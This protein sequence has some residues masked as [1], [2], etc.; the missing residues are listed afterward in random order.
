MEIPGYTI[1][2]VI[3]EGGMATVY[4][5]VQ[6]SLERQVALK[7][8]AKVLVDDESFR[9]RFLKEAKIIAQ[10]HHP[11]IITIHDFGVYGDTY[12]ICQEY[13]PGGTLADEITSGLTIQRALYILKG[14]ADALEYAHAKGFVHRDIK[15]Q[16][17]LFRGDRFRSPVLTDFGIAKA[18]VP[19]QTQLTIAN[20][21]C[22][23]PAYASPEQA[24]G[25]DLDHRSDLYSLGIVFYQMLTGNVPYSA[26]DPV[27]I[28]VRHITDPVPRLPPELAATFQPFL[29]RCL[30]KEPDGRFSSAEEVIQAIS[31][32]DESTH[33][34]SLQETGVGRPVDAGSRP[35]VVL[36]G[37]KTAQRADTPPPSAGV[38]TPAAG[39][40]PYQSQVASGTP[41]QAGPRRKWLVPGVLGGLLAA[42]AIAAMAF[43]FGANNG[44]P[45]PAVA[46]QERTPEPPK[47]EVPTE[48]PALEPPEPPAGGLNRTKI[49]LLLETAEAL[50]DAGDLF[51]PSE[52]NAYLMYGKILGID[53]DNRQAIYGRT[54]IWNRQLVQVRQHIDKGQLVFAE[55][56]LD[57]MR[58]L[59]PNAPGFGPWLR[60]LRE[61]KN[62]R[63]QETNGAGLL[64]RADQ[65]YR[66]GQL[67]APPGENAFETLQAARAAE[68]DL[69]VLDDFVERLF[70]QQLALA[71]AALSENR[72]DEGLNLVGQALAVDDSRTAFQALRAKMA[73]RQAQL[74]SQDQRDDWLDRAQN[75]FEQD[76]LVGDHGE[77]TAYTLYS[78]V[79]DEDPDNPIARA[80]VRT[81][82]R[83]LAVQA[84]R[85]D[86]SGD[87]ATA[88][89]RIDAALR[90]T[91]G[92]RTL[93][94][95]RDDFLAKQAERRDDEANQLADREQ[96]HRHWLA[97]AEDLLGQGKLIG[98]GETAYAL[99]LRILGENPDNDA[100]IEG[101]R[102]VSMALGEQAQ[103]LNDAG[104]HGNALET[105]DSALRMNPR[106]RQLAAIKRAI[107]DAQAAAAPRSRP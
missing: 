101:I 6:Q 25:L 40:S 12:Y 32:I 54:E 84:R 44:Q 46:T 19:D 1:K 95:I 16:N 72:L 41:T 96:R 55:K 91:P 92:D 107:E 69:Q 26:S 64:Q 71:E 80:G 88:L 73:H 29:D 10:L 93:A 89:A 94:E 60:M 103:A 50:A 65:Q 58:S 98:T 90:I 13:L 20:V 81:I 106:D 70:S 75:L 99:L 37:G 79:L 5:A 17:V 15:P 39:S 45:D 47:A 38:Q 74:A 63:S 9:K 7:V 97:N 48:P 49:A 18:T 24:K 51:S 57:D 35:T 83:T 2:Q 82:V 59:A 105:I 78:R 86:L 77:E 31:A 33:G 100:A 8:M 42:A 61:A 23:S 53:E 28:A 87:H 22:G 27:S 34:S 30:A 4:L 52:R 67:F 21:F 66:D 43:Y 56:L 14:V 85:L 62:A 3:G 102:A 76:R 36:V 68:A 11:R 104:E